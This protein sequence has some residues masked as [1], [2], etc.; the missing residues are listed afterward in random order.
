MPLEHVYQ[1]NVHHKSHKSGWLR[2]AVLGAND[3]LVSNASLLIG[4]A[5]AGRINLLPLTGIAGIAAG[6]MSMAVGEYI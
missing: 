3:G 5:A 1:R 2:A 4:I 6:S